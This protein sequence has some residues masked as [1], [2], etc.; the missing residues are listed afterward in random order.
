MVSKY[1][2]WKKNNNLYKKTNVLIPM[3]LN[4]GIWL[5]NQSSANKSQGWIAYYLVIPFMFSTMHVTENFLETTSKPHF[6][7]SCLFALFSIFKN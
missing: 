5:Y 3:D 2:G 6:E 4:Y 7:F 1:R